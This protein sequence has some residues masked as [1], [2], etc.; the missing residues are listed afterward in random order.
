LYTDGAEVL[1]D[2]A[3]RQ[4]DTPEARSAR[5][6]VLVSQGQRVFNDVVNKC[7]RRVEFASDSYSELIHLPKYGDADVLVD[8]RR[9]IAIPILLAVACGLRR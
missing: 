8:P 7:L 2:F 5:E 6:F 9:S 4:G 3:E 1:Y